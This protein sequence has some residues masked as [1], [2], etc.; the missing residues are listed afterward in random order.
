[1][2]KVLS[3]VNQIM[4]RADS[5]NYF[6]FLSTFVIF[7]DGVLLYAH[8][9]SIFELNFSYIKSS[10]TIGSFLVFLCVYSLF[11]AVVVTGLKFVIS[12]IVLSLPTIE[13]FQHSDN[14]NFRQTFTKDYITAS[15]MRTYAIKNDNSVAL[16]VVAEKR[17]ETRNLLN[18]EKNC[19]AFLLASL[20]SLAVGFEDSPSL[21]VSMFT[22]TEDGNL[23]SF[24]SLKAILVSV[25]YITMVY[26]G[27]IRG[28]CFQITPSLYRDRIYFPDNDI[29]N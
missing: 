16:G 9:I 22:F 27:V 21:V 15:K 6:V 11:M 5:F 19:F 20:L 8:G 28:C 17:Q 18:L 10:I 24:E 29:K 12:Q 1:M 7:L 2:D 3:Y 14:G 4:D 25:V 26:L 13:F 23:L